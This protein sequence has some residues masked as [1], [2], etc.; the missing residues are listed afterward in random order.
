MGKKAVNKS[1]NKA[2]MHNVI[3]IKLAFHETLQYKGG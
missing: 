2:V 1:V 3:F